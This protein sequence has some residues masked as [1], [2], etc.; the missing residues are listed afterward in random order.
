MKLLL[1]EMYPPALARALAAVG[2]HQ[3]TTISDLGMN[4]AP[5]PE[6]F[7]CAVAQHHVLLT[8]NVA[9]FVAIAAQHSTTGA[10]HPGL[11]IALSNRFT[12]RPSGHRTLIDAIRAH[13]ATS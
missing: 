12:R 9:D 3:A 7:A 2:I 5:D 6:V 13:D 4:G 8:E 11:M 10:H 1:D